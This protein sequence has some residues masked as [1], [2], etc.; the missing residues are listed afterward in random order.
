[1]LFLIFFAPDV[2]AAARTLDVL[3]SV[4]SA[5]RPAKKPPRGPEHLFVMSLCQRGD[6]REHSYTLISAPARRSRGDGM[7]AG[8]KRGGGA[9]RGAP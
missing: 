8:G 6:K 5:Q 3:V 9:R 7:A 4:F 2:E 1:M